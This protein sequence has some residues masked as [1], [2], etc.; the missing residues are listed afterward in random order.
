M[1]IEKKQ[2]EYLNILDEYIGLYGTGMIV[3]II[4]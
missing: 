3:Y 1:K 4:I 2:L